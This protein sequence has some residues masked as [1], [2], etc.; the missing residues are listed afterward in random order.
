MHASVLKKKSNFYFTMRR[1]NKIV[2]KYTILALLGIWNNDEQKSLNG[3][4]YCIVDELDA[5]KETTVVEKLSISLVEFAN[6]S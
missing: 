2:K 1:I 3:V 5:E 4:R 6:K